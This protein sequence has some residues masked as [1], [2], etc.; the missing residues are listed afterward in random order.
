MRHADMQQI[1]GADQLREAVDKAVTAMKG[2][3]V[4]DST[5]SH[6]DV[7]T[8]WILDARTRGSFDK[9]LFEEVG[10]LLRSAAVAASD[11]ILFFNMDVVDPNSKEDNWQPL[12]KVKYEV[13]QAIMSS[14]LSRG[15]GTSGDSK[16][17]QCPLGPRCARRRKQ[18]TMRN[19]GGPLRRWLFRRVREFGMPL[20]W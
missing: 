1:K 13:L 9:K 8:V 5:S 2:K 6:S 20:K 11:L 7:L 19:R 10:K 12:A 16:S 17:Q 4:A 3:I 15:Q 14:S 18:S